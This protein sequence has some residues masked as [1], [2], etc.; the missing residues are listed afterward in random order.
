MAVYLRLAL[1]GMRKNSRI[2]LPYLLASAGMVAVFY[3]IAFLPYSNFMDGWSGSNT[4]KIV[5]MLG[6][7]VIAFF[8]A[9]FLFYTNS[10]LIR[11]RKREFGL[12]NVLGMS[13]GNIGRVL[14][15]ETLLT[16]AASLGLA[17]LLLLGFSNRAG[18]GVG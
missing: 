2:Y 12:Y 7:W 4:L 13:K 6:I 11:R 16:A 3:I 14:C 10:F 1:L 18:L 9:I 15:W 17:R 8:A 5:L